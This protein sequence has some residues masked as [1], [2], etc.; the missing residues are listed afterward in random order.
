VS[1]ASSKGTRTHFRGLAAILALVV[2]VSVAGGA[3]GGVG[4]ALAADGCP[5]PNDTAEQACKLRPDR[6]I[7]S[8]LR[9]SDDADRLG[10]DVKD[11]QSVEVTA[12]GNS[13]VPG[14]GLKLRIES[15]DGQAI[16][17]VGTGPGERVVLAERLPA[18]RSIIY[19]SL[20][21]A[22]DMPT[23]FFQPAPALPSRIV[24]RVPSTMQAS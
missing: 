23:G 7:E 2:A 1:A 4:S 3:E 11:G 14:T 9:S 18:W 5:E 8:E 16:A 21:G 24:E 6:A 15:T 12:K 17:E 10:I 19:L 22:T 13:S 20:D